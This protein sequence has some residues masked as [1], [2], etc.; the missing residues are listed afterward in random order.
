MIKFACSK[1]RR[2]CLDLAISQILRHN[3]S[4][5]IHRCGGVLAQRDTQGT[6]AQLHGGNAVPST[7]L[8]RIHS[9]ARLQCTGG[10][11]WINLPSDCN[12]WNETRIFTELLVKHLIYICTAIYAT[13]PMPSSSFIKKR[14]WC[15][16]ALRQQIMGKAGLPACRPPICLNT[17]P[18]L[19][20]AWQMASAVT[21][22]LDR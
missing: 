18:G 17:T 11:G 7:G 2:H 22:Q 15:I 8:L 20:C 5:V 6:Q 13:I 12:V 14:H 9:S 3:H 16:G 19:P 21:V 4:L 10:A 1:R